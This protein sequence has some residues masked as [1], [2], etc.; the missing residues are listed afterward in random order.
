MTEFPHSAGENHNNHRL[1][2][3]SNIPETA[4]GAGEPYNVDKLF[5]SLPA[6]MPIYLSICLLIKAFFFFLNLPSYNS[7]WFLYLSDSV[8]LSLFCRNR[9]KPTRYHLLSQRWEA[10]IPHTCSHGIIATEMTEE[11]VRGGW[12]Q[13]S[14]ETQSLSVL[15]DRN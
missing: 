11:D 4:H 12:K 15:E 14:E 13:A 9:K 8:C 6:K 3:I 2:P 1:T 10:A 5:A 7:A